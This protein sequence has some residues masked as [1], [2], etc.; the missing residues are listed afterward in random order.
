MWRNRM[1]WRLLQWYGQSG[2]MRDDFWDSIILTGCRNKCLSELQ[3]SFLYFL[4]LCWPEV[5]YHLLW[6]KISLPGYLF[7]PKKQY[8][9]YIFFNSQSFLKRYGINCKNFLLTFQAWIW[10]IQSG[11]SFSVLH[12]SVNALLFFNIVVTFFCSSLSV[13]S[14]PLS[15]PAESEPVHSQLLALRRENF[16]VDWISL[17]AGTCH[18]LICMTLSKAVLQFSHL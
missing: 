6:F 3:C 14:R 7:I 9:F 15:K 13:S 17:G 1:C 18:W 4:N 5:I 11:R 8:S 12:P 16:S 10:V 2:G